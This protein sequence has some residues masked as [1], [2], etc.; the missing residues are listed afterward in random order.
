[1][2]A[3]MFIFIWIMCNTST[4]KPMS[5]Q[6]CSVWKPRAAPH[7]TPASICSSFYLP[8]WLFLS[9]VTLQR[10]FS[11][12]RTH[13]V[14]KGLGSLFNLKK[15]PLKTETLERKSTQEI[16]IR[17]RWDPCVFLWKVLISKAQPYLDR[18]QQVSQDVWH[19]IS[20]GHRFFSVIPF[21]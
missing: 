14:F 4:A 8:F 15:A 19:N 11:T 20:V 3:C 13:A 2:P 9:T 12:L 18:H 21:K 6:K 17:K 10:E 5:N 1:M 7:T 16:L